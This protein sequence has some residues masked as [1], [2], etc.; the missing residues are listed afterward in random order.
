MLPKRG[1]AVHVV[2]AGVPG[3]TFGGM[4]GRVDFERAAG[5]KNSPLSKEATTTWPM[6]FQTIKPLPTCAS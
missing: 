6:G 3:G 4:L 2:N 1:R 5:H